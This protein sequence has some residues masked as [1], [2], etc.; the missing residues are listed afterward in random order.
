MQPGRRE[1]SGRRTG[2][3]MGNVGEDVS[4]ESERGEGEAEEEGPG[5]GK[6]DGS[7]FGRAK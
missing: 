1:E 2:V 6:M 3:D 4:R 7:Y 5:A